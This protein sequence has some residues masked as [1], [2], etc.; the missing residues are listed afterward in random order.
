MF[1]LTRISVMNGA[2]IAL[3]STF[4]NLASFPSHKTECKLSEHA[5]SNI[6]RGRPFAEGY[7]LYGWFDRRTTLLL[8]TGEEH[9]R[10]G[11][12]LDTL[13]QGNRSEISFWRTVV[14]T[15]LRW[16][17]SLAVA[18]AICVVLYTQQDLFLQT[19]GAPQNILQKAVFGFGMLLWEYGIDFMAVVVV[20][21]IALC[22]HMYYYIG[23][24]RDKWDQ[25][26]IHKLFRKQFVLGLLPEISGLIEMG[27]SPVESLHICQKV[28]SATYFRYR[29]TKL[30]AAMA[31]GAELIESFGKHLLDQRYMALAMSLS[32]AHPGEPHR[33]LLRLRRIIDADVVANYRVLSRYLS[34]VLMVLLLGIIYGVLEI[35]YAKPANFQ[36]PL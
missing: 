11:Q 33:V 27:L 4:E 25:H 23:R 6:S 10:L 19:L 22:Y 30:R 12:T 34:F 28:Y 24:S 32:I 35:I 26:G 14:L 36:L 2:G 21:G 20:L 31:A 9:Q 13:I 15:N 17:L 5:L 7:D 8:V 1:F 29:L 16:L 18:I 3:R